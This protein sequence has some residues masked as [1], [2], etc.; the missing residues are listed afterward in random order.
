[1]IKVIA[2][3]GMG[4]GRY[5]NTIKSI[6]EGISYGAYGLETDV[7]LTKDGIVVCNH[8]PNLIRTRNLDIE[9]GKTTFDELNAM[10]L[11]AEDGLTTLENLFISI[12]TNS[13]F[14]I[15]IKDKN[16][17]DETIRIV[18]EFEA[19]G[20]C[21][22]SSFIHDCLPKFRE[23]NKS[24]FIAPLIDEQVLKTGAREYLNEV[25]D[26]YKP[27]CLNLNVEMFNVLGVEKARSIIEEIRERGVQ[28]AFWTL[29]NVKLLNTIKDI[30]DFVITDV[31]N[32]ILENI[33]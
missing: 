13:Y 8:D 5:E 3:R 1:M 27:D 12:P 14:D 2:H 22:F 17:V 25:V 7:R 31:S 24:A 23:A 10:G 32:I 33:A 16:A 6:K 11:I 18:E 4:R 9:I 29:N 28:I 21:M 19:F 30:C 20:K 26:T 15:E